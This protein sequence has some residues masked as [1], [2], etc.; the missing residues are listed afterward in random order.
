M[1]ANIER[2]IEYARHEGVALLGDLYAPKGKGPHPVM[3]A[4]HGGGWQLGAR[5]SYRHWGPYLAEHGIALF[6]VS[7]RFAKPGEPSYPAAVHDIRAAVQFAK[8]RAEALG[9]DAAR[10]GLM[11]DSAGGHLAALVALAGD[12]PEFAH[13]PRG[14]PHAG[15]ATSVKALIGAYGVYDLAQQWNHDLRSRPRDSICEKFLGVAPM[16]D[17]HRY[18]EAS[19]LSYA[20]TAAN[21]TAVLLAWGTEDDIVDAKHQSELFLLALKQ[22]RF[23]ARSVVIPGAG[24][25]WMSDPIAEHDSHSARFAPR[26]LRFLSEKL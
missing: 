5:E 6:A 20:V 1:D 11:G 14:N 9:L 7:Y 26:V 12:R 25:F 22:A 4:V 2:G 16:E 3:V 13:E 17:R 21:R 10:V 8:G 24:H 15:L 18:F 23:F 19:P